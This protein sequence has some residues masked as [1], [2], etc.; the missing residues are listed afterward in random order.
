VRRHLLVLLA[1]L[2]L[3]LLLT[4]PLA[5]HFADHLPGDGSD[6]PAIA[7]NLWWVKYA[8]L[9][10][11]TNPFACT[12]LF[13]PIGINLAFYTLTVLNAALSLPLQLLWGVV[14]ASNVMLLS[15]FVLGGY[16]AFL[17]T[18][19]LLRPAKASTPPSNLQS[20]IPNPQPPTSNLQP[21]IPFIA[22]AFYAFASSKLFYAALGQFNIASSQ[23]VPFYILYLFKMRSEPGRL[24]H[25]ILATA[26]LLC[27]AWAELTYA[28]FLAVFTALYFVYEI[29]C[30]AWDALQQNRGWPALACTSGPG[31][32]L[33]LFIR[34]LALLALLSTL[35]LAPILAQMLP[36]MRVEG[37]FF[38]EGSG[39]AESF[40]ADL[41]GYLVPTMHHP[42]FGGLIARTGIRDYEKGQHLYLG[43]SLLA[44]ALPG[45]WAR[46][47]E[48]A[49]RFWG[50][51]ALTFALLS[52][53]PRV[54]VNGTDTGVVGPFILLQDLPFFKGNR[55]PSRYSVLLVLSLAVLA[56]YGLK[57]IMNF[58]AESAKDAEKKYISLPS[59]RPLRL[60]FAGLLPVS[61]LAVYLFEHL[62]V[63]LP[64]SDMRIP[65]VYRTIAADGGDFAVLDLPVA[66]RNGFRV[67]GIIH[68]VFM[69]NQFY[70][71]IHQRPLLQGNTSRNPEFKFQYFTEA[72]LLNSLIALETGHQVDQATQERDR[73]LASEVL[74]FFNIRYILIH[75]LGSENPAITPEALIPYVE[76][77]MPVARFYDDGNIVAYQVT[78]PPPPEESEITPGSDLLRIHLGEGWSTPTGDGL[79]WA[80]RQEARLFVVLN[81]RAQKFKLRAHVPGPGQTL[82]VIANGQ[83]AGSV[84][85]REG[86]GDYEMILPAESLRPGLNELHL[87][88][89][90]TFPAE[91]AGQEPY[92]IGA[93]G[94]SSPVALVVRSAGE[95]VGDFGHI[96]LNGRDVSP[97][98]RGYNVVV[99]DPASGQVLFTAAFDTFASEGASQALATF[100][101]KLPPG[102]IVAV[103]VRD[104]ASMKLQQK[105]V[106]A[107][108][109]IG[110]R[111]DLRGRFR[112]SHAIL[113]V[114]G[115]EPGQALEVTSELWPATVAVG[116]ALTEPHVT[117]GIESLRF[118][119]LL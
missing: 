99:L 44:L 50:L 75:R 3:A 1:Y 116:P 118:E 45:L 5:P 2:L 69:F 7:W 30:V 104:E 82:T 97:G 54:H 26:F 107:L 56:A 103:A 101:E 119:P 34:N 25:V 37:D 96:Y 77:T 73:A 108:R 42:L 15:S 46:R 76:A 87:R 59:L 61:L 10:L 12:Y 112:W 64:L 47:R 18:A 100:I 105:G 20:P 90:R 17:L 79:I 114:K 111:G 67:T 86:R 31:K 48:R 113:G 71:T 93:T 74:R 57:W 43:Y 49:A 84:P 81:R 51:A 66:W 29:A 32:P 55:Y 14:L 94:I 27:Q 21:L 4:Y 102:V 115:A 91:A 22:G 13:Y 39:F 72:P 24:R 109:L 110:A 36:D 38:V 40:S 16:G 8:L 89:S 6:D 106:E 117:L 11:R 35:G 41:V 88:F 60:I 92:L 63:P 78:L 80:Q 98:E 9:N 23:W 52:L 58:T 68:P 85:L 28:S 65:S 95:E 70:Q 19:Y 33:L 83:V 62:S 53:G